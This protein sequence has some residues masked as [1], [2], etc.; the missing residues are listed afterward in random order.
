VAQRPFRL[1]APIPTEN[2]VEA[3][4]LSFLRLRG[5][6][7]IRLHAGRFKTADGKRWIQG[8]DRGT[9]DWAAIHPLYPGFL[10]EAKRP[11]ESPEPHQLAKITELQ[12][13]YRLAIEVV[14]SPLDLNRWL[15]LHERKFK[16]TSPESR[17]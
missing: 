3:G 4:C 17:L 10:F 5:Y 11:G 9:P 15:D 13:A 8:V 12:V 6:W 2:D 14:H 7:P 1:R 16:P